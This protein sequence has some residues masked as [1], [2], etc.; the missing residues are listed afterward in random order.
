MNT[1]EIIAKPRKEDDRVDPQESPATQ[2]Y[3]GRGGH[4]QRR[5]FK[6]GLWAN[7]AWI[8]AWNIVTLLIFF[9]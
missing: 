8:V 6:P 9:G 3:I 5:W 4:R 7:L 2:D 1:T